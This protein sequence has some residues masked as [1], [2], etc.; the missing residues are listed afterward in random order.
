[1]LQNNHKIR[2]KGFFLT[3]STIA[4]L[5]SALLRVCSI[6]LDDANSRELF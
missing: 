5:E 2:A 1:M 6:F 3:L 4:G